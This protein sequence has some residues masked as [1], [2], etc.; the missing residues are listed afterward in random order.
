MIEV[1]EVERG[2]GV[3]A[4]GD[5]GL[6][7]TTRGWRQGCLLGAV[8]VRGVREEGFGCDGAEI[9]GGGR[10]EEESGGCCQVRR[11]G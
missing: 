8:V 9:M 5:G 6:G 4:R 2:G 1:A 7:R 3:V 11:G 10:R